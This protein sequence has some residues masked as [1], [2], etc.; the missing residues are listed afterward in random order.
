[1]GYVN[2]SVKDLREYTPSPLGVEDDF[3]ENNIGVFPEP[4]SD[5]VQLDFNAST[6]PVT[7]TVHDLQGK[8]IY[9]ENLNSFS[10]SVKIDVSEWP[11]GLYIAEAVNGNKKATAR[12]LV[13]H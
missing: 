10:A 5:N 12:I 9:S 4:A 13:A 2:G 1:M 8:I 3:A 11:D 7:I 6:D